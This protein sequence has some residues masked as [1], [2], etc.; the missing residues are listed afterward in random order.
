MF[1]ILAL[2][3]K[4]VQYQW[5]QTLYLVEVLEYGVVR[6]QRDCRVPSFGAKMPPLETVAT[7][8]L[9]VWCVARKWCSAL[10]STPVVPKD[11]YGLTST[12]I[13]CFQSLLII[14]WESLVL[15]DAFSLL[16]QKNRTTLPFKSIFLVSLLKPALTTDPLQLTTIS[17]ALCSALKSLLAAAKPKRPSAHPEQPNTLMTKL[18]VWNIKSSCEIR[19]H[20][21]TL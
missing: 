17:T 2:E 3:R 18:T 1:M 4:I 10:E 13:L 6:L 14:F 15:T 19:I 8:H 12:Y 21:L 20:L 7:Q 5:L 16:E 11:M 9:L